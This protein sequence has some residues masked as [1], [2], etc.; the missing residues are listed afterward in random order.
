MKL[1][2][3][4]RKHLG[5]DVNIET[6]SGREFPENLWDYRLVIH[7]GGCM[8]NGREMQ[9][10]M[11]RAVSGGLPFTNYGIAIAYMRGILKRSIAMLPGIGDE[12]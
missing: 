10:R 3:L 5:F 7:C 12:E 2:K 9:S 8:L 11:N 1:P 6:S 4:L